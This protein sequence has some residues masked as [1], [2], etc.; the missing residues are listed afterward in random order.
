MSYTVSPYKPSGDIPI[1]YRQPD[2]FDQEDPSRNVSDTLEIVDYIKDSHLRIWY[3]C[4]EDGYETHHHSAIEIIY[5]I[6]NGYT[7]TAG[8]KTFN[9]QEGE[10]LIIPS[11]MIHR[12]LAQP[13]GARFVMLIDP[14]PLMVYRDYKI[15]S[16]LFSQPMYLTARNHSG[17]Y[18]YVADELQKATDIYFENLPMWEMNVYARLIRV[19]A[20]IGKDFFRGSENFEIGENNSHARVNYNKFADLLAMVDEHYP[21]DISLDEAADF[22]GFSKFH[23]SRLFK[24]YTGT[25]FYDHLLNRRIQAA[26]ELLNSNMSVTDVCYRTGFHSLTSFSRSFKQITGFS[27]KE[28]RR[29]SEQYDSK[30]F[31]TSIIKKDQA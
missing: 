31:S 6:E 10:I 14:E 5:C 20:A 13:K 9:L 24:E 7:V 4:Q 25:T 29:Y 17:I 18:R 12:L 19:F 1:K 15:V 3:N 16:P 22:V 23:F 26:E 2:A 11:H 28:Y 27:P 8:Q 30:R 21:D